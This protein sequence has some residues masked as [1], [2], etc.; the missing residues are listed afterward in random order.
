MKVGIHTVGAINPEGIKAFGNV[1]SRAGKMAQWVKHLLGR[2][3]NLSSILT[4][5]IKIG[6][7][8]QL[9]KAGPLTPGPM[10]PLSLSLSCI[11]THM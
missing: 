11:H 10:C 7:K 5:D 8:K 6:G 2:P 4:T 1:C 9:H 3:D